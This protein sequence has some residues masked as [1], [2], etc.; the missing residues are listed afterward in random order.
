MRSQ[1]TRAS[2]M[3]TQKLMCCVS[4]SSQA[5]PFLAAP[6]VRWI[7]PKHAGGSW[8]SQ[9][10]LKVFGDAMASVTGA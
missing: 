7:T 4:G 5:S 1:T 10:T 3:A 9:F 8:L 6:G 2:C